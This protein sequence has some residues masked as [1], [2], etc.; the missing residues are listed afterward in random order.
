MFE[1]AR[2]KLT[3]WYLI[4]I[5][6]I[7]L[8]FSLVI[9]QVFSNQIRNR[10]VRLEHQYMMEEMLRS[11]M[12]PGRRLRSNV[13]V[14][15][16]EDFRA[17]K[18]GLVL[19]LFYANGTILIVS[20]GAGYFLAGRTL[21]PIEDT[22]EEQKRFIADASHELR[23]PLTALRTSIEVALRA[24]KIT[25]DEAKKILESNL[26]DVESLQSLIDNLLYLSRTQK[27]DFHLSFNEIDIREI[28]EKVV[29][30]LSPLAKEKN[31]QIDADIDNYLIE[32]DKKSLIKLFQILLDNAIKYTN[33][34]GQVSLK[35]E[36]SKNYL[37]VKMRDNGIGINRQDLPHIY[38]RFYRVDE[39]R[40][41]T[42]AHG[43]GLGLSLA[44]EIIEQHKGNINVSSEVDVGTTFTIRLP[45][46]Q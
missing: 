6:L 29:K 33:Q 24:K 15:L 8:I 22:M 4:I 16:A 39:A 38:D 20:A 3:A 17:A 43:F 44:K 21:K 28:I 18:R 37:L 10:L 23:T 7:S 14:I 27:E 31:I 11:P 46:K 19:V 41:K 9:Y 13:P 34:G 2:I 26:E 1:S 5:M 32:A 25:Q 45:I 36:E 35:T 12:G 42:E 30:K 40:V